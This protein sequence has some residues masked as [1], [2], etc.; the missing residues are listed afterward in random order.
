MTPFELLLLL[1]GFGVVLLSLAGAAQRFFGPDA[2]LERPWS[3][4]N[5]PPAF[6]DDREPPCR[7]GVRVP[8]TRHRYHE[9]SRWQARQERGR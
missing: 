3:P 6:R 8:A 4:E 2:S 1:A 7:C 5:P 9:S